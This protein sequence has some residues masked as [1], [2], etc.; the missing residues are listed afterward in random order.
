MK[1]YRPILIFAFCA[2]ALYLF[3]TLTVLGADKARTF[4][5]TIKRGAGTEG[6]LSCAEAKLTDAPCFWKASKRIPAG[7]Y[8]GGSATVMETKGYQAVEIPNVTGFKGIFIHQGSSPGFSDG[9]IVTPKE[10]IVTLWKT[11]P[12]DQHNITIIVSDE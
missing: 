6:K 2:L 3:L 10:N 12:K 8:S 4:T 1:T 11:I 5:I 9:C 7:T